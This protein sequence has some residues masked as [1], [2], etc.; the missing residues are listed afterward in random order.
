[1]NKFLAT[2]KKEAHTLHFNS[3]GIKAIGFLAK[4]AILSLKKIYFKVL[5]FDFLSAVMNVASYV[6]ALK[7]LQQIE[8]A[9][10][11]NPTSLDNS[12]ISTE[13]TMIAFILVILTT[14]ASVEFRYRS[15]KAVCSIWEAFSI[16]CTNLAVAAINRKIKHDIPIQTSFDPPKSFNK[17]RKLLN[18]AINQ[19]AFS[20]GL[21]AKKI[22]QILSHILQGLIFLSVLLYLNVSIT[23]IILL[24]S[25]I[26]FVFYLRSYL[27]VAKVSSTRLELA[28]SSIHEIRTLH[29]SIES[30]QLTGDDVNQQVNGLIDNGNVGKFLRQ[31]ISIQQNIKR[32]ASILEYANPLTFMIIGIMLFNDDHFDISISVVLIYFLV[33]RKMIAMAVQVGDDLIAINNIHPNITNYLMLIDKIKPNGTGKKSV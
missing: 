6:L 17:H 12:P 24:L 30:K 18:R 25:S 22:A 8:G 15:F 4:D 1:M 16:R 19:D 10:A 14:S 29:E 32:G 11:S 9:A 28:D 21:F 3:Q 20:V 27:N 33:L 31:K 26:L 2:L 23:L 13:Y 5:C 7:V